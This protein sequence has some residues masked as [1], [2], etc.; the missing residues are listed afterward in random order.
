MNFHSTSQPYMQPVVQ[1]GVGQRSLPRRKGSFPVSLVFWRPV[2]KILLLLLSLVLAINMYVTSSVSKV[3]ESIATA[4]NRRHELMDKNIEL[5]ALKAQLR[6]DK[7]IQ[8]LA[9]EKLSLF[10]HTKGQVGKFN[11]R[12]G[13]FV[14]L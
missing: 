9:A 11:H 14:Y 5:R 8:Q 3:N 7:Q 2:G 10:V 4:A 12:K 6:G 1:I 13:Y